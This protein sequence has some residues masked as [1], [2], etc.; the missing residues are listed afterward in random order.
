MMLKSSSGVP[1]AAPHVPT[2]AYAEP[3]IIAAIATSE[4]ASSIFHFL[5]D[6]LRA[7]FMNLCGSIELLPVQFVGFA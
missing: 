1:G 6:T 3:H 5:I 2:A 4:L 7:P